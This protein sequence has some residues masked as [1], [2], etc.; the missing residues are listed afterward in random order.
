MLVG[1][2]LGG[3]QNYGKEITSISKLKGI[4]HEENVKKIHYTY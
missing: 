3:G 2:G 1:S 4:H